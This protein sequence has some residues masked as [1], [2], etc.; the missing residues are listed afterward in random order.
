MYTNK[1]TIQV[2][3][4]TEMFRIEGRLHVLAGSRLTDALN[5]KSKDF[6]A[7]TEAK[8]Y[9]ISDDSLVYEPPYI[10]VNR[11]SISCIFPLE[12]AED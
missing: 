9:A 1:D 5:S 3:I 2:M 12:E 8:I 10:A 7:I 6:L 4:V 11:D